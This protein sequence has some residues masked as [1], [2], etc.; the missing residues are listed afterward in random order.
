MSDDDKR[1]YFSFEERQKQKAR[2]REHDEARLARGKSPPLIFK[3]KT[4]S[5]ETYVLTRSPF[6][7]GVAPANGCGCAAQTN[8]SSLTKN[9][10]G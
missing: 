2:S 4:P 1:R 7:D 10:T 9:D 5:F 6:V 3:G 8:P